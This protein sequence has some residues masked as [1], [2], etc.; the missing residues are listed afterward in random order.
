MSVQAITGAEANPLRT[1]HTPSW[2]GC[3]LQPNPAVK[4]GCSPTIQVFLTN[5]KTKTK[6]CSTAAAASDMLYIKT[7]PELSQKVKRPAQ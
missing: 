4:L 2:H 5:Q 3:K 7:R 1:Y 6:Q